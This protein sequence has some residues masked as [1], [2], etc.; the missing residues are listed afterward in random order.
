[1]DSVS[2]P[3]GHT[4]PISYADL[5]R[6]AAKPVFDAN[7][8]RRAIKESIRRT[9]VPFAKFV[10]GMTEPCHKEMFAFD[11]HLW[12]EA[13]DDPAKAQ[14]ILRRLGLAL[15]LTLTEGHPTPSDVVFVEIAC[16]ELRDDVIAPCSI[17]GLMHWKSSADPVE[18]APHGFTAAQAAMIAETA[19]VP[20]TLR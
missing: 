14:V 17:R 15:S 2:L 11:P 3:A 18:P 8:W 4:G 1:M 9:D 16:V 20:V 13:Q 7:F 12:E 6:S 19:D 10:R 5:S